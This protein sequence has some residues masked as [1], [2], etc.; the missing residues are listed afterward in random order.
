MPSTENSGNLAL[1]YQEVLTAT[2]RL[3]SNRQSVSSAESFRA[4]MREALRQADNEG[5][6]RGYTEEES[7]L[8]RFATVAFLDESI[9]NSRNPIFADWP[10]KPLQ[11]ELFGVHVAGEIFFRNL[12][13][14]LKDSDSP[15]LADV[16]EVYYLCLLLGFAGRYSISAGS[17]LRVIRDSVSEKMR[18]IRGTNAE[19]SPSWAP[20]GQAVRQQQSDPWISRLK[21]AALACAVLV[22]LLFGGYALS[23]SSDASELKRI[24]ARG[25]LAR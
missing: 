18:R 5:R 25:A 15:S 14:L 13:K 22:A 8:A 19:F 6:Q 20:G 16:L 12:E 10:R 24:S 2:V 11:E 23:L 4:N 7:R 3:R 9:L 1:I 21:I 17:E